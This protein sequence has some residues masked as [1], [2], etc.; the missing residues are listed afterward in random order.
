MECEALWEVNKKVYCT[1]KAVQIRV[2]P[3][4]SL[5]ECAFDDDTEVSASVSKMSVQDSVLM[6]V[7]VEVPVAVPVQTPAP[8]EHSASTDIKVEDDDEEDD[9]DIEEDDE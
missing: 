8:V 9:E 4:V 7:A 1:F 6:P 3:P 2:H 5:P